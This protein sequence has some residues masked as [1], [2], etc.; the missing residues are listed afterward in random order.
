MYA[1]I[2]TGG[3]QERVAEGQQVRVELLGAEAGSEVSFAPVLLVD[4]RKI[5]GI[6]T[7]TA[8]LF[9]AFTAGGLEPGRKHQLQLLDS[10]GPRVRYHDRPH[11]RDF[12]FPQNQDADLA[13][14]DWHPVYVD[15]FY[16]GFC[17]STAFSPTDVFPL[18][19]WAKLAMALQAVVSIAVIGLVIA[20]AV[21]VFA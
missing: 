7:D 2:A 3:K 19:R 14:A 1:V 16:L 21:N 8:R 5:R 15:Y 13:P 11:Y 9:W 12:A 6:T 20:R 18:A 17:T 4:G 10:G